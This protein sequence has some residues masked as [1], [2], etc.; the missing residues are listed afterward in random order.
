MRREL[1][2]M[3][4]IEQYLTAEHSGVEFKEAVE[5][6]KFKSW[7]KSVSAFLNTS[8]GTI[9]FGVTD[10]ERK[11]VGVANAHETIEKM[12]ELIYTK[13]EPTFI[14]QLKPM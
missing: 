14:F 13:I 8:G 11:I 4:P 10:S 3:M 7:L 2:T 5:L 12:S 9:I 6:R 1:M